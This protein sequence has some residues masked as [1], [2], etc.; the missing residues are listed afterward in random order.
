MVRL[1]FFVIAG[2]LTC[3]A[4]T[5][6]ELPARKDSVSVSAGFTKDELRVADEFDSKWESA[7]QIVS[8]DPRNAIKRLQELLAIIDHHAFLEHNRPQLLVA[9]GDAYMGAGELPAAVKVFEQRLRT[10]E[11]C[12]P[13]ATY[14][15][16]CA[17]AQLDL[18][19]ARMASGDVSVALDLARSAVEN[20]RQQLKLENPREADELQHFVH[21]RK[22]GQAELMYGLFLAR[23]GRAGEA[24][25]MLGQCVETLGQILANAEVQPS[26]RTDAQHFI[27]LA[28]KQQ[29][30]LK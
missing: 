10:D 9:L 3:C 14:P 7:R 18:A 19:T 16:S 6:S 20:F 12:K 28:R 24:S 21:L 17:S 27:D 1:W 22:L 25:Q 11:E 30:A 2:T 26:L 4:Q 5:A 13:N 8:T 23:G 29:A 15:A